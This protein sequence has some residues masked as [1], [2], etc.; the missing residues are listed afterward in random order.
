ME[1]KVLNMDEAAAFLGYTKGYM[2][3]LTMNHIL[4]YSK[5]NGRRIFFE[6]EKLV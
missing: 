1:K 3:Q 2:Y 4:P 6:K 5:P